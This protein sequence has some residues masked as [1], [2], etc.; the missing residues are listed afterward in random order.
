MPNTLLRCS[1]WA[2]KIFLLSGFLSLA[3]AAGPNP[4]ALN[5]TYTATAYAQAGITASGQYTHRHIVAADPDVLPIGSRIKIRRAGRYS[6]EYVVADTGRKIVGR[7]L[8]IFMP[9]ER[10]CVKFGVKRVRVRVIEVGNGTRIAAKE[11]DQEVKQDVAKELDKKAV[12]A[13]ATEDDWAKANSSQSSAKPK[14]AV[15]PAPPRQ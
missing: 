13:A 9:S 2:S 7:R 14:E 15:A 5:G 1:G 11:A 6:G 4:R 8:D 3:Q 10:A 12:G